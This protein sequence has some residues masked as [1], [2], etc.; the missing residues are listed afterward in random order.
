MFSLQRVH[1][2]RTFDESIH[3]TYCSFFSL[4][5]FDRIQTFISENLF[6]IIFLKRVEL[7]KSEN[8]E[9]NM[10]SSSQVWTKLL[11]DMAIQTNARTVVVSTSHIYGGSTKKILE[12]I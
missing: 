10:C 8:G 7:S 12:N 1:T 3:G 2:Y 4:I 5:C 6:S 9:S 11:L